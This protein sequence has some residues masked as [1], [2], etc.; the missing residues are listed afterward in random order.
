MPDS[1]RVL[2]V[3]HEIQHRIVAGRYVRAN[4]SLMSGRSA[5]RWSQPRRASRGAGEAGRHGAGQKPPGFRDTC[6]NAQRPARQ[7]WL[8]T[9][10]EPPG[11]PPRTPLPRPPS[12]GDVHRRSGRQPPFRRAPRRAW[13]GRRRYWPDHAKRSTGASGP[14]WISTRYSPRERKPDLRDRTRTDSGFP[15]R[16]RRRA[17]PRYGANVIIEHMAESWPPSGPATLTRPVNV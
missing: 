4:C 10:A 12:S 1:D 14:T 16:S 3:V 5:P 13:S 8:S 2:D 15:A 9:P 17:V 11:P 7:R 6:R